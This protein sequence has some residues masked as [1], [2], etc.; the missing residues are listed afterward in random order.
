[1]AAGRRCFQAEHHT[2]ERNNAA[3]TPESHTEM[4][5]AISKILIHAHNQTNDITFGNRFLFL[6]RRNIICPFKDRFIFS[7]CFSFSFKL[8]YVQRVCVS[9]FEKHAH[10]RARAHTHTHTHTHT[11]KSYTL[12]IRLQTTIIHVAYR[13]ADNYNTRY[14]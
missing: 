14:L 13:I 6:S 7:F 5:V 12:S 10:A 8:H 9:E 3:T 2:L 1:M 4:V 11:H